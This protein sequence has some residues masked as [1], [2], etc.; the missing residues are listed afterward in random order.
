M[1]TPRHRNKSAAQAGSRHDFCHPVTKF[2]Q[3]VERRVA[4]LDLSY[5]GRMSETRAPKHITY[6]C[7]IFQFNAF[8]CNKPNGFHDL[9]NQSQV[10]AN[11]ISNVVDVCKTLNDLN[12]NCLN[13]WWTE[14]NKH[15]DCFTFVNDILRSLMDSNSGSIFQSPCLPL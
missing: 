7:I 6:I 4:Y 14:H 5:C 15:F 2:N 12:C 3:A 10:Y 9:K 1:L 13:N 11:Y 8:S